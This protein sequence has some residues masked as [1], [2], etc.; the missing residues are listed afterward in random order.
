[1]QVSAKLGISRHGVLCFCWSIP[2]S[3]HPAGLHTDIKFSFGTRVL[4]ST[5]QL[6]SMLVCA[7]QWALEQTPSG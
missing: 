4:G 5:R 6:S 2:A 1:M 7:G 3:L